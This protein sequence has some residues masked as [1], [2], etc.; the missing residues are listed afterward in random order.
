MLVRMWKKSNLCV[1]LVGM[2]IGTATV[3]NSMEVP[4]KVK[5]RTTLCS[6][7]CTTRYLSIAY[8]NFDPKGTCTPMFIAALSI[9]AKLWREP[10]CPS[11][12]EWINGILLSHQKN[13]IFPF[14]MTWMELKSIM[15][16]KI[17]Q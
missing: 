8:K 10:K 11:T 4:Q 2:L 3:E 1:L 9:I 6:H 15:L 17:S 12:D 5:N 7:Y 16:S 14:A 13:E